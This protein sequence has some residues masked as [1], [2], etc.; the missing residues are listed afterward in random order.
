VK[1]VSVSWP[2]GTATYTGSEI[3][4]DSGAKKWTVNIDKSRPALEGG[5]RD[6]REVVYGVLVKRVKGGT[7]YLAITFSGETYFASSDPN[8]VTITVYVDL[9]G[10][11]GT[12]TTKSDAVILK[13]A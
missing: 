11:D 7:S 2:S 3:V 4:Y 6:Y 9:I 5:T 8:D 10:P 13:D 1:S 12:V